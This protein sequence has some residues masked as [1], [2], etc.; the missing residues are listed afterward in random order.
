[1]VGETAEGTEGRPTT[2][3]H[4]T[5]AGKTIAQPEDEANGQTEKE[6]D[7]LERHLRKNGHLSGN[8]PRFSSF[9]E[10]LASPFPSEDITTLFPPGTVTTNPLSEEVDDP[11]APLDDCELP[12]I[13]FSQEEL[14]RIRDPWNQSLIVKLM[15]RNVSYS[16]LMN[17]INSLWK[18]SGPI[19][20]I[21]L[22][23]HYYLIKFHL[24]SD[25]HKVLNDGPWFIGVNFLA[26]QKWEPE[27]HTNRA[28]MSTTVIWARL[29][30]LPIEYYDRSTLKR[31]GN[32]LGTLLKIDVHT[33]NGNRGRFARL[34]IQMDLSKPLISKIKVGSFIQKVSYEGIT[35]VCF[36]CGRM[37]HKR[38]DCKLPNSTS[39]SAPITVHTP[40][41]QDDD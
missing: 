31:L 32:L 17:R 23:N 15:G 14:T 18:P 9:K 6:T 7:L 27:F 8:N 36:D 5:A 13:T 12:C 28:I 1:M 11:S 40:H 10:A 29:Q 4:S 30:G 3:D 41:E 39:T 25:L 26:L 37:G 34:C 20:G 33:E 38:G 24:E 21:D 22:G 35:S 2:Q 19:H 16:L